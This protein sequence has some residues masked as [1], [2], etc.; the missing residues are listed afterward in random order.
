MA[1]I[2]GAIHL[3]Q[4]DEL[5]IE[6]RD[7]KQKLTLRCSIFAR[8]NKQTGKGE[9]NRISFTS[10]AKFIVDKALALGL[11]DGRIDTRKNPVYLDIPFRRLYFTMYQGPNGPGMQG[12]ADID[13]DV[14]RC[15]PPPV[16]SNHGQ[17]HQGGQQQQ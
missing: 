12:Y 5:K 15:F 2:R 3:T 16:N 1:T 6:P 10:D 9:Y 13:G 7:G 4:L 17:T 14:S 8:I 11:P